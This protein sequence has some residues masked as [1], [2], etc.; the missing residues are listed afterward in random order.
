MAGKT[1]WV[2]GVVFEKY[3]VLAMMFRKYW[4][5]AVVRGG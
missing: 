4:P 5:F 3:R 2:L 1:K